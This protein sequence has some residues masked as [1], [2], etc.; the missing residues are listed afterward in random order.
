MTTT[1][2]SS[3][4]GQKFDNNGQYS[5]ASI[6]RYEK[7]FG[8][9]YISTGGQETT[10]N[11]VG[12][13]K[14]ALKPGARIL[15]V[16]SGIGGAAFYLA[17]TYGAKVVGI[18]LAEEMVTLA[19]ENA[20]KAGVGDSVTTILG[21]ILTTEFKEPFDVIWSRDALMHI[22]DKP[23]LFK[24]LFDLMAPGGTLVITDYAKGVGAGSAEFQAYVKKTGYSLTDPASYGKLL[25]GAGFVDVH[26]EDA[27]A[28]FLEIMQREADRLKNNRDE[29]LAIFGEQDLNYLLERWLAKDGYCKA[30]DMKWGIYVAHK[31]A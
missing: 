13:I 22:P 18:D 16:G 24:R 28:T 30:G 25:E 4:Q 17:K 15:D 19:N 26:A 8:E 20:A 6:L 5:R 3:E 31:P 23:R 29:F 10:D 12:R 7:I 27:T 9:G 2:T 1:A 21:D 14:A 11:L